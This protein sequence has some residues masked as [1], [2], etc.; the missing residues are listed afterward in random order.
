[1]R[2]HSSSPVTT[3][4]ATAPLSPARALAFRLVSVL[5]LPLLLL[6]LLEG[7]LRLAGIGYPPGFT[8]PCQ[9]KGQPASC[10][11]PDF[12]RRFF[13]PG[14]ARSPSPLVIPATK[15]GRT[16]RIFILGESAAQGDPEPGFGFGRFLE[17]MLAERHPG[18]RFEVITGGG[19]PARW[20]G[21]EMFLAQQLRAGDPA[22]EAVY[23]GFERNLADAVTAA[24][25]GGAQVVVSTMGTWLRDFAPLASLHRPGLGEEQLSGWRARFTEGERL[26]AEGRFAEAAEAWRGAEAIDA[27]HAELQYRIGLLALA[28]G[29]QAGARTRLTRARDLDTLRFRADSR[30][31][32]IIRRVAGSAGTGVRLVDGAAAL[33]EASDHGLPGSDLFYEHVHLTPAGNYR[34][35]AALLPAVEG[36]LPAGWRTGAVPRAPPALGTCIERLAFTGF[37]RYR[38]AKEVLA[39]LRRPPLSGQSDH[40]GQVRALEREKEMGAAEP[41]EVSDATYRSALAA[42]PGDPWLRLNYGILLDT[43]DLF[44]ARRG[45]VDAGRSLEQYR[46]ALEAWPQSTAAHTRLAE[47]LLRLGRADEAVAQ[48][49]ALQAYRPR[50]GQG[51]VTMAWALL[52]LE[53]YAEVREALQRAAAV[54]PPVAEVAGPE[55]LFRL[56]WALDRGGQGQQARRTLDEAITAWR[57]RLAGD[58]GSPEVLRGLAEALRVAGQA[59]E[60]DALEDRA[61]AP[62]PGP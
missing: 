42:R 9:V 11:N 22:M 8:V 7:G 2:K 18:V 30:I 27:E 32:A 55:L 34:L 47:G 48:C 41:F 28:S 14:L 35:A 13:P 10:E 33:A 26:E 31:D 38:V 56:A 20:G 29:D 19:G 43:R 50:S 17:V 15:Q 16:F 54:D 23:G 46:V 37:D 49:R 12:G 57:D 59:A 51:W 52:R 3:A 61:R 36:A 62:A 21:M 1:M 24:R 4:T 25:A 58:P 60:A 44:L 5:V 40:G 39:R 45:G 6:G 53:R